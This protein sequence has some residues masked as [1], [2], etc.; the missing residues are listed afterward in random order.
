MKTKLA[1]AIC[2]IVSMNLVASAIP[3]QS[4]EI[5]LRDMHTSEF[6]SPG[7]YLADMDLSFADFTGCELSGANFSRSDVTGSKFDGAFLNGSNFESV[8]MSASFKNAE[9]YG[10]YLYNAVL[11]GNFELAS[12]R[13]VNGGDFGRLT[14]NFAEANLSGATFNNAELSGNF[15]NAVINGSY[16]NSVFS[17]LFTNAQITNITAAWGN[18]SGDFTGAAFAGIDLSGATLGGNFRE[19][20]LQQIITNDSTILNGNFS[21]LNLRGLY[22]RGVHLN[23]VFDSADFTDANLSGAQLDGSFRGSIFTRTDLSYAQLEGVFDSATFDSENSDQ[24]LFT[25]FTGS[26]EGST[27]TNSHFNWTNLS[28]VDLSHSHFVSPMFGSFTSAFMPKAWPTGWAYCGE[29]GGH[30]YGPG[31]DLSNQV[32]GNGTFCDVSAVDWKNSLADNSIFYGLSFAGANSIYLPF[33]RSVY[34]RVD[35]SGTKITSSFSRETLDTVKFTNSDLSESGFDHSNLY[36]PDFSSANLSSVSFSFANLSGANFSGASL[37]SADFAGANL[38]GV[39][40]AGANLAG[41]NFA[42]ANFSGV[43]FSGASVIG[44]NFSGASLVNVQNFDCGGN[45]LLTSA[46][47]LRSS[48]VHHCSFSNSPEFH[49]SDSKF[50]DSTF[51]DVT[52]KYPANYLKAE[53]YDT[54]FTNVT[55]VAKNG[56]ILKFVRGSL[57]SALFEKESDFSSSYFENVITANVRFEG[58]FNSSIFQNIDLSHANFLD[59]LIGAR[60]SNCNLKFADF[61]QAV[62][63]SIIFENSDLAHA[64]FSRANLVAVFFKDSNLTETDFYR[65]SFQ[66]LMTHNV[67]GSPVNLNKRYILRGGFILG[68][69]VQLVGENLRNFDFGG[70]D[71]SGSAIYQSDISGA[72]FENTKS[73]FGVYSNELIGTPESISKGFALIKGRLI[74]PGVRMEAQDFKSIDFGSVDLSF[75]FFRGGRFEGSDLSKAKFRGTIFC[76]SYS[77][78]STRTPSGVRFGRNAWG[79][80]GTFVGP[81]LAGCPLNGNPPWK[82]SPQWFIAGSDVSDQNLEGADLRDLSFNYGDFARVNL[83]NANLSSSVFRGSNFAGADLRGANLTNA[84]FAGAIL[85]GALMTGITGAPAYL[86]DGWVYLNGSIVRAGNEV[87]GMK[88]SNSK[89]ASG[90]EELVVDDQTH[91]S[92][93]GDA[94]Y[95]NTLSMDTT[96]G[97]NA[98]GSCV[99]WFIDGAVV[100]SANKVSFTPSKLDIGKKVRVGVVRTDA[101]GTKTIQ[102]SDELLVG[103][104]RMNSAV[105]TVSG[106]AK[107]GGRLTALRTTWAPG[108]SYSYQW[109]RNGTVIEGATKVSY[110]PTTGDFQQ[111][112]AV[113]VCATK[114]YFETKCETSSASA[115][116]APGGFPKSPVVQLAVGKLTVGSTL[117][118]KPGNWLTGTSLSFQWLRDGV[119]I[120]G[121]NLAS[122]TLSSEDRGHVIQFQVTASKWGYVDQVKS[123]ITKSIP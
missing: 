45:D 59:T 85:E 117:V 20:Q 58:K 82:D 56:S 50:Y 89:C 39:D 57:R 55:F 3:A 76:F 114:A 95:S 88:L 112:L 123:S 23:G 9:F 34:D 93:L 80:E 10:A 106:V 71:L 16:Y 104:A 91:L 52:F 11:S 96:Q 18:L 83:R 98:K 113:R 97:F 121:A 122:Y 40:F 103:K 36:N 62:N 29:S 84:D 74:G 31:Q 47:E 15:A 78:S 102:L 111:T 25:T 44:A 8:N 100:P 90:S 1:I 86:P 119:A 14:G 48:V 22:L 92:L 54:F 46:A 64:D 7:V 118:G 116:V 33:S 60:F 32:L 68:P 79:Q 17:G 43:N 6:C 27:F 77:D 109:F 108:A 53:F 70:V 69:T 66:S 24:L 12:L 75:A 61:T 72:K 105:P 63:V 81:G 30:F 13:N 42:G 65:T 51:S 28:Q 101:S 37:V 94:S 73:L 26:F 99:V 49:L 4:A 120:Q 5:Q 19:A 110:L 38:S 21:D 87:L 115:K 2:A 67:S 35:F 41:V 107:V